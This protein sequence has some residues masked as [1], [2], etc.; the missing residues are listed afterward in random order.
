MKKNV[1]ITIDTVAMFFLILI[2]QVTKRLAII[3]LK[4]QDPII[5]I[6]IFRKPWCRI[7]YAS[8]QKI[9]VCVHHHCYADSNILRFIQASFGQKISDLACVS[10]LYCSRRHR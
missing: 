8:K 9:T 6:P 7:W 4:D 10:L 5:L 3:N 1:A 2:D